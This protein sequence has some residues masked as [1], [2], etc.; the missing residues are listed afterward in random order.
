MTA[1]GIELNT[2]YKLSDWNPYN[3]TNVVQIITAIEDYPV[4]EFYRF[5]RSPLPVG[6]AAEQ[7]LPAASPGLAGSSLLAFQPSRLSV[8]KVSSKEGASDT[9]LTTIPNAVQAFFQRAESRLSAETE[10][11]AQYALK[12]LRRIR[13][14]VAEIAPD[15]INGRMF[16]LVDMED[17]STT[18]EWVRNRSRLGFVLDREN[19]SSWFVV[20]PNGESKSGYL[21]GK[22]GLKSLRGLLEEFVPAEQ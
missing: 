9:L 17:G 18:I 15:N 11:T 14:L 12:L 2:Y 20:L 6:A 8:A 19:E 4:T 10:I 1:I 5:L 3:S 22:D 7:T 16:A 13:V 21:Y